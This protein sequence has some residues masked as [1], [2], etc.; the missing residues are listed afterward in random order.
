MEPSGGMRTLSLPEGSRSR[1]NRSALP[2]NGGA[3]KMTATCGPKCCEQFARLRP[4]GLWAKTFSELLIG[5]TDWYSSRCVMAWRLKATRFYRLY[6]QLQASM[7]RTSDT[8][9]GLLPTVQTQGLKQCRSGKSKPINLALLPTPTVNDSKNISLPIS[10]VNRDNL[11]GAYHRGMLPTPTA[12]D[13]GSGRV[14]KSQSRNAKARPTIAAAF[15]STGFR[16]NP[17][18]VAEMMSFP[19]DWTES[20]FR[21]GGKNPSRPTETQSSRNSSA[22]SST[23]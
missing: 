19:C 16:L 23:R 14:N 12:I 1:A 18:F 9:P 10:Q 22:E 21:S 17:R 8:E 6:F 11:A 15:R 3:P 5:R 20:P 7:R 4:G 2:G 13:A